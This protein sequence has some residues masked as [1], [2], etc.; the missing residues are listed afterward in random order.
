MVDVLFAG[1]G[2][3]VP[4]RERSLPCVAVRMK[5]DVILF[6]CGEGSQRQLMV[7]PFSFM[8]VKGI[9]I[10]HLHGDHYLGIPGLLQ[11]MSMSG[12]K[13]RLILAGPEGFSDAV[14]SLMGLC[15][16]GLNYDIDVSDA[17]DGDVFQFKGFSVEAFGVD[18]GVPALGFVFR[19]DDRP[20]K[21]DRV[22][23]TSLGLRPG[24]D[25]SRLQNGETVNG[26]DP[27]DIIGPIRKGRRIV[28]S[29]DTLPCAKLAAAAKDADVLIHEA[30][31][32][33]SDGGLAKEHMH[34]TAEDAATAAKDAGVSLLIVTH[35]SNRYDDLSLIEDECRSIFPNS[36]A[37]AD[38]MLF[39]VK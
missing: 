20:G 26:V 2:A 7:S 18:H 13:D 3:S 30:T 4:S 15:N 38:M 36:V 32:L 1:T 28:Y 33:S 14:D 19:E 10:S 39:S 8:K 12:R 25:F 37:A 23:A 16:G 17:S 11:T 5:G 6:D 9:F 29:G 34:S 21:F 22:K 31:Y 24:P 35:M 27:K